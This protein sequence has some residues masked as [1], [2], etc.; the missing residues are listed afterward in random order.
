MLNELLFLEYTNHTH[1]GLNLC[2]VSST[3]PRRS[4][5]IAVRFRVTTPAHILLMAAVQ[6]KIE[7][8]ASSSVLLWAWSIYSKNSNSFNTCSVLLFNYLRWSC[9]F[10][11]FIFL[12]MYF[13]Y[14]RNVCN[15]E[16]KGI[17]LFWFDVKDILTDR[18]TDNYYLNYR[19]VM[20]W[21]KGNS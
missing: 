14:W 8:N 6:K 10:L 13:C 18:Q 20:K 15:V 4:P 2:Q 5:Q 21:M 7:L 1:K 11:P 19:I 3:T 17:W 12:L 9:M 16:Y